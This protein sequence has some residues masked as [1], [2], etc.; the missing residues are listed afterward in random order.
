[1]LLYFDNCCL[2][3]PY[4]DQAQL[5]IYLETL[6]KLSIQQS[7]LSRRYLLAWSYVLDYEIE[8][9]PFRERRECFLQ[10]KNIAVSHCNEDDAVLQKAG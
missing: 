10:W 1:M 2:N 9:S 8:Q 3:R 4:D 7:V 5:R 6:A